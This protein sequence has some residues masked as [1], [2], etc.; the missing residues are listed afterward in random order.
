MKEILRTSDPVKLSWAQAML[1]GA[2]ID[3]VVLDAGMASM[4]GG[5]IPFIRKR[6]MV[7][8]DDADEARQLLAEAY[9]GEGAR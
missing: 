8:D 1:A 2:G 3:S 9:P 5:G 7:D 4:L 6:L